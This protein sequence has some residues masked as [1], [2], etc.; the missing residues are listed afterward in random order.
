M[1][2]LFANIKIWFSGDEVKFSFVKLLSSLYLEM[3]RC[4]ITE[5]CCC[6]VI[7]EEKIP[8]VIILVRVNYRGCAGWSV[9]LLFPYSKIRFSGDG[10]LFSSPL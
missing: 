10:A 1:R 7:K 5:T 8:N 2:L 9:P 4:K 6:I 3:K